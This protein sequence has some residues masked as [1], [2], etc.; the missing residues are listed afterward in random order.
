MHVFLVVSHRDLFLRPLVFN[1]F[2]NA[3]K[4]NI[5]IIFDKVQILHLEGGCCWIYKQAMVRRSKGAGS[6]LSLG[7][8]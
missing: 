5:K 4:E 1:T 2:V 3:L 7:L 8:V 6:F